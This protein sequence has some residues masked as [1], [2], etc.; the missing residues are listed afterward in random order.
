V[1]SP[2]A[3][4]NLDNQDAMAAD[5]R[6]AAEGQNRT[7]LHPFP[8]RSSARAVLHSALDDEDVGASG[9][10][11]VQ[12]LIDGREVVDLTLSLASIRVACRMLASPWCKT[13]QLK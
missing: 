7:P 1:D 5:E 11:L 10:A 3:R 12:Q 13:T 9:R 6:S 4:L 2:H 8:D